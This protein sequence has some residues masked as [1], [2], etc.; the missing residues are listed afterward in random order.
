MY[1]EKLIEFCSSIVN[2]LLSHFNSWYS[3]KFL[4]H[5]KEV[6]VLFDIVF[7]L[8]YM[9][10]YYCLL[11]LLYSNTYTYAVLAIFRLCHAN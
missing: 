11:E 2:R 7:F 1:E 3:H 4:R 6:L 8:V 9:S 5:A 10:S